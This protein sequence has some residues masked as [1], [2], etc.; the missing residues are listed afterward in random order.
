MQQID[1]SMY[2]DDQ[3][4]TVRQKDM[5]ILLK[6]S[7]MRNHKLSL[8]KSKII[9]ADIKLEETILSQNARTSRCT[10]INS[11]VNESTDFFVFRTKQLVFTINTVIRGADVEWTVKRQ[12]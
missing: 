1:Q 4:L 8:N 11:Q 10:V 9:G 6:P 2:P 5:M 12:E 7:L 3:S